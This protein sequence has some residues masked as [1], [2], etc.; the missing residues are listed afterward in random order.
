MAGRKWHFEVYSTANF[1]D[2]EVELPPVL[3]NGRLVEVPR[4][5]FSAGIVQW[6]VTYH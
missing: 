2:V 3:V 6:C 1:D 5:R 4:V